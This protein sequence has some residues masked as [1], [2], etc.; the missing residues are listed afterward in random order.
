MAIDHF[1]RVFVVDKVSRARFL[2]VPRVYPCFTL[3]SM[4][5]LASIFADFASY[6]R[7]T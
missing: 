3:W 5:N 6:A 4:L 7:D 1:A 2:A